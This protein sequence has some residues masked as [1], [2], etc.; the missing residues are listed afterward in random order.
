MY[1]II[2]IYTSTYI[3]KARYRN[4]FVSLY[5]DNRKWF[6]CTLMISSKLF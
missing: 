3:Q 6:Q 1:I 4:K 2:I 5:M